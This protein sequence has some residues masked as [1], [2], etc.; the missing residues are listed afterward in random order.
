[1]RITTAAGAAVAQYTHLHP[2]FGALLRV[3]GPDS[4]SASPSGASPRPE[5]LAMLAAGP[6]QFWTFFPLGAA[7]HRRIAEIL[8]E[9]PVPASES[10]FP[11]FRAALRGA[12]GVIGWRLWDG[13]REWPIADLS[14]EQRALPIRAIMNDTLLVER[15][16]AGWHAEDEV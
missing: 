7:C 4:G 10:T 11:T 9:A 12:K 1:V 15:A 6:T 16:V 5:E 8:G 13:T 2:E 14:P 3:L